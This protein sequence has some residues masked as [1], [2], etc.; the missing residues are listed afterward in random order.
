MDL[1]TTVE[2]VEVEKEGT[3]SED[4]EEEEEAEVEGKLVLSGHC[5][6]EQGWLNK[7]IVSKHLLES[8]QLE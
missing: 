1:N 5:D 4:E 2:F 6:Y 3:D 7:I 8:M